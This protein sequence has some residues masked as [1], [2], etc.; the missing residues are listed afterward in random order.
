VTIGP[1]IEDGFYYD[2][3]PKGEPQDAASL[4]GI[5]TRELA[6]A[7]QQFVMPVQPRAET[8]IHVPDAHGRHNHGWAPGSAC[9]GPE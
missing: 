3:A 5:G 2:F 9:S 6:R 8:G 7:Q 4:S 1:V